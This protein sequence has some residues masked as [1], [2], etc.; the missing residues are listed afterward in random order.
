MPS[1]RESEL[2][3]QQSLLR[4]QQAW[5]S[6]NIGLYLDQYAPEFKPQ[7]G[8]SRSEWAKLR[9]ERISGKKNIRIQI[10]DIDIALD[11]DTATT[12]FTQLY[13]DERIKTINKKRIVWIKRGEHWLIQQ[14]LTE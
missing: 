2:E 9:M 7:D 5:S 3:L 4:W 13:A 1:A 12:R 6:K 11:R 10:E 8:R 14:E